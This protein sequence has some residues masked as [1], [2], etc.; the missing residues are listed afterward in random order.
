MIWGTPINPLPFKLVVQERE[1]MWRACDFWTKEPETIA[2]IDSFLPE[3]VFWDIG[4][5]IGVFSLYAITKKCLAFAFEPCLDNYHTLCMNIGA[6]GFSVKPFPK[7]FGDTPGRAAFNVP[8]TGAGRS[9][10]QIGVPV[11]ELGRKFTPEETYDVEVTMVDLMAKEHGCPHYIKIDVDGHEE[12]IIRGAIN[13]LNNSALK[14]VL[15]EVNNNYAQIDA[16]M[17]RSGFTDWNQFNGADIN[18]RAGK[19]Q[20]NVVYTR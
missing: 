14:S 17:K 3:N 8:H 6:N 13:T 10:G 19:P 2:W 7:A 20:R 11:D 9:G 4:A 12:A 15:V 16:V 18:R 1:E 5:N